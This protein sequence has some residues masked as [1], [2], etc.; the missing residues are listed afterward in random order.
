MADAR[1]SGC[2][3]PSRSPTEVPL[4][5][6]EVILYNTEIQYYNQSNIVGG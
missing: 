6:G 2:L 5:D 1:T 3:K 4:H